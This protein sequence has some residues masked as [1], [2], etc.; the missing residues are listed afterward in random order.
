LTQLSIADALRPGSA[1]AEAS[2]ELDDLSAL[3]KAEQDVEIGPRAASQG[4]RFFDMVG[5]AGAF[6][7]GLEGDADGERRFAEDR[8]IGSGHGNEIRE[9]D[10]IAFSR[11]AAF[12]DDDRVALCSFE[13]PS[14]LARCT[15]DGR[16]A[17]APT[18]NAAT[19]RSQHD[20]YR[21]GLPRIAFD[22][23]G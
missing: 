14:Q 18:Y 22:L 1:A 5:D 15:R 9:V 2:V 16:K 10:G 20:F 23:S 12:A 21:V 8:L 3:L 11:R 6:L 4:D 13:Q 7:I 19:N 17:C